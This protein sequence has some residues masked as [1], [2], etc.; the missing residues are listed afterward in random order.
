MSLTNLL[1]SGYKPLC[2]NH[3]KLHSTKYLVA[4]WSCIGYPRS[5]AFDTLM[6]EDFQML[7]VLLY[8][9]LTQCEMDIWLHPSHNASQW[10]TS[11]NLTFSNSACMTQDEWILEKQ[12]VRMVKWTRG[13]A[14]EQGVVLSSN[15]TVV[16]LAL[17][18]V[19]CKINVFSMCSMVMGVPPPTYQL[20]F[21]FNLD[22]CMQFL[23]NVLL[24]QEISTEWLFEV[25]SFSMEMTFAKP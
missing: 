17:V 1:W 16:L 18:S 9:H 2:G 22:L 19:L 24:W 25:F 6:I 5:K 21:V 3:Y 23:W 11:G 14:R 4:E 13:C 7:L 15:N 12:K 8:P 10:C 20:K